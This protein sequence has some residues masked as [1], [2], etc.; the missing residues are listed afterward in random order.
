MRICIIG[1]G[2]YVGSALA[3]A[4]TERQD[5]LQLVSSRSN[6]ID[7]TTGLLP[8]NFEIKAGTDVVYY[9]AQSPH[10][11]Q[12]PEYAAHLLSVNCATAVQ[13]AFAAKKAG[14][15]RFIYTST[16]SVYTP[17]F[18]PLHEQS[19]LQ[20]D[21]WYSLSKVQA[22]EALA[23]FRRDMD[24]TIVRPFGIYGPGQTDKLV[25]NL[26][27]RVLSG[28][29]IS[30]DQNPK[31]STDVGGLR[32]SLCYIHDTVQILY[33]L[34]EQTGIECL[35][36]AGSEAISI[37]TMVEIMG[38]ISGINAKII[39]SDK[40]RQFDLIADTVLLTRVLNPEF[41]DIETGLAQMLMY[42]SRS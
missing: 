18:S 2:G 4:C 3:Q 1:S 32:I 40:Y 22:E 9:L 17:S 27:R 26:M 21:N 39:L 23:L 15:K 5:K 24:I 12:V 10:Y 16:G 28:D 36:L 37:R 6:G 20:R 35:N 7:T 31:D 33:N 41:T 25:P 19:P 11:R 30:I 34:I 8:S 14:V 38:R 13:A 42:Q 29:E